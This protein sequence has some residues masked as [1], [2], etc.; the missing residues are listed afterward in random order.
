M[1]PRRE[2]QE[3]EQGIESASSQELSRLVENTDPLDYG[4][5]KTVEQILAQTNLLESINIDEEAMQFYIDYSID[6]LWK[7]AFRNEENAVMAVKSEGKNGNKY[8]DIAVETFLSDYDRKKKRIFD[9]VVDF[10]DQ[11]IICENCLRPIIVW[12]VTTTVI[13]T[14]KYCKGCLKDA[15]L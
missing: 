1:T 5:I 10:N 14:P 11:L 9:N 6:E 2:S 8:H 7:S 15:M 4:E 3:P 13:S 12:D